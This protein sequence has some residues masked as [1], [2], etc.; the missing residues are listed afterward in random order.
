VILLDTNVLMYAVGGEHPLRDPCRRLLDAQRRGQVELMITLEV[1]QEFA[2]GR[3]RRRPRDRTAL[4]ARLFAESLTLVETSMDD[5][6]HGLELFV[7]HPRLS[8]IDGVLAAVALRHDAEAL[9][10]ADRAFRRITDLRHV[11]PATPALD[12][13]LNTHS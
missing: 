8:V 13:L 12:A 1:L 3:A 5:L 6:D 4:L 2:Y 11:D 10:S 9:V 7:D